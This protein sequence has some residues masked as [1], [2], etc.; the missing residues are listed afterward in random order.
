MVEAG[1]QSENTPGK[2]HDGSI[3]T[4]IRRPVTMTLRTRWVVVRAPRSSRTYVGRIEPHNVGAGVSG[5]SPLKGL[6][7][8]A[9]RPL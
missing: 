4:S 7:T 5:T 8:V 1:A 2:P 3:F 6:Q 9:D